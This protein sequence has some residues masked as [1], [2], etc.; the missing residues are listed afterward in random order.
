MRQLYLVCGYYRYELQTELVQ[1]DQDL[2]RGSY[3]PSTAQRNH[4]LILLRPRPNSLQ[5]R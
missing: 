5:A 2:G 1:D 4:P 3:R